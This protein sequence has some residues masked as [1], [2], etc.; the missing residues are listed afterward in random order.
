[1]NNQLGMMLLI[2]GLSWVMIDFCIRF[3]Y[4]VYK[5]KKNKLRDSE[6]EQK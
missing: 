1:M 4:Q 2:S 3:H 5:L 6:G